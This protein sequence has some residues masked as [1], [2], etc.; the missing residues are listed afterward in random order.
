MDQSVHRNNFK[1]AAAESVRDHSR[2]LAEEVCLCQCTFFKNS[3]F[4]LHSIL[5]A[6]QSKVARA[7]ICRDVAG[8]HMAI[9]VCMKICFLMQKFVFLFQ[10]AISLAM[11]K[12]VKIV[13]SKNN[14]LSH[15]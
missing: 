4:R 9:C 12:S 11:V 5:S 1:G 14:L 15:W 7:K 8:N 6:Q 13:L 3:T 2:T 10:Y